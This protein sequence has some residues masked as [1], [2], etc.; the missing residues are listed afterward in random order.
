MI[1]ASVIGWPI[2]HSRSPL[3][4]GYWLKQ[5]NIQGS[6]VKHAVSP[7]QLQSFLQALRNG[8]HVGTNV[9]I[10]YKETAVPFVDEAD[11]RVRR[12]GALNTIW[13]QDG[14]LHATATDGQGFTESLKQTLPKRDCFARPATILGAGGSTRALVDE[15]LR[16]G[17]DHINIWNR[18]A[19]RAEELVHHF[20]PAL[21]AISSHDLPARL[22]DTGLLINTTSA[23]M[24]GTPALEVPW[25]AL[26]PS[27]IVADI[28]YTPLITEFLQNA[29]GRGHDIVPGLGMLLHQAVVGF[30][31]WFGVKPTV[32][33]EL[34]ELVA[35]DIDPEYAP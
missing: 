18:S 11:E 27:A 29:S 1:K 13:R 10:P 28:V 15:L 25:V 16:E 9:T 6:Y 14:K 22:Q 7:D 12:I 5:H 31:K 3:I 24:N 23:G 8:E 30:E 21:H 17:I 32:T 26:N 35:K 34:Y 2:S 33:N 20:G 19:T 4:H